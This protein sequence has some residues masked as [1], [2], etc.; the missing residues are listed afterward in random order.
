MVRHLRFAL[1]SCRFL[2]ILSDL[3]TQQIQ[4]KNPFWGDRN[5][6]RGNTL[7]GELSTLKCSLR[8]IPKEIVKWVKLHNVP[9]VNASLSISFTKR[10]ARLLL[11][12]GPWVLCIRRR[13]PDFPHKG[14][15]SAA[16][17]HIIHIESFKGIDENLLP[18]DFN[19]VSPP[20]PFHQ[21][22]GGAPAETGNEHEDQTEANTGHSIWFGWK[23]HSF[24]LSPPV[25]KISV[26]RLN[27]TGKIQ[28]FLTFI[29]NIYCANP[30][31]AFSWNGTK[32]A[33]LCFSHY[34][35]N[36]LESG[37]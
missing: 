8:N 19:S 7:H 30:A 13:H 16:S 23:D 17:G 3:Y 11:R 21:L 1:M 12:A 27:A 36:F 26:Y 14:L 18:G 4:A 31:A 37:N 2:K 32:S 35:S 9:K 5:Y 6:I 10:G 24:G 29:G 25:S 33:L 20:H 15:H 22:Q 34:L 28:V